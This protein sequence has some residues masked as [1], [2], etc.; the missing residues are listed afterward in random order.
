MPGYATNRGRWPLC[1]AAEGESAAGQD[2]QKGWP[3][4]SFARPFPG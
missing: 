1:A 2:T 4:S 3:V